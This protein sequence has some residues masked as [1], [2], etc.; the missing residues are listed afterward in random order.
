MV[1]GFTIAIS[2]ASHSAMM[3]VLGEIAASAA[4]THRRP[5]VVA[6]SVV[7]T[8]VLV[9]VVVVVVNWIVAM[10]MIMIPRINESQ[11]VVRTVPA[12]AVVE[13]IVIPIG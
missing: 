11:V 8:V 1:V 3:I 6:V 12:P 4:V 7:I 2:T 13:T 9:V 10:M 5:D